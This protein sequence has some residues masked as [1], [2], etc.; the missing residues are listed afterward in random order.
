M[1]VKPATILKSNRN[2]YYPPTLIDDFDR[3][4]M[5][6]VPNVNITWKRVPHWGTDED[7]TYLRGE[8]YPI[9]WKSRYGG[10]DSATNLRISLKDKL[11]KGDYL[12]KTKD[13]KETDIY[14]VTWDVMDEINN[15]KTQIQ[16]VNAFIKIVRKNEN[17]NYGTVDPLT[18]KLIEE[19]KSETV[20]VENIPIIGYTNVM[21]PSYDMQQNIP[22]IIPQHILLMY[23][24]YNNE[25]KNVEIGDRFVWDNAEYVIIDKTTAELSQTKEYGVLTFNAQKVAGGKQNVI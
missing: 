20:I 21:R 7:V 19:G 15:R 9:N 16:K 4:L 22:A 23:M 18:G 11:N 12:I 10:S 13:E 8:T 6:D 2:F 3:F 14:M 24:Q 1:D 17:E 5:T 25:S